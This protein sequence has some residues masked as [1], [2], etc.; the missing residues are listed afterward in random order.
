VELLAEGPVDDV[1]KL[2]ARLPQLPAPGRVDELVDMDA[3]APGVA[4][5]F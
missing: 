1:G 5:D 4:P 2:V 3:D